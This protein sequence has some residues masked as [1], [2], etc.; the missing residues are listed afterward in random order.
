MS[1]R[2]P[3]YLGHRFRTRSSALKRPASALLLCV[4]LMLSAVAQDMEPR[5][6]TPLP[7][8]MNVIGAGY[9]K[10]SGDIL[11]D[12]VLKLENVEVD[13]NTLGISYVRSFPLAGKSARF[14]LLIPWQNIRW[15]GLL[16]GE[17]AS[18]TRVGLA[19][20]RLR[21]SVLLA[22]A[23]AMD[24]AEYRRHA[25]A[26]RTNTILGASVAV[27]VPAGEYFEDK[28][29]NLGQNRYII[30]PQLG[31]VHTRG[32]WA[33]ELTGSTL[34]FTDNDDFFGS[35]KRE[36]EP[37]YSVQGHV[38]RV[39]RP[40]VWASVG[41]LYAK[42]GK[43]R[44]NGVRKDDQRGDFVAGAAFGVPITPSQGVKIAY[45][46]GRTRRDTGADTQSLII[47]WSRR[48]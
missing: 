36:Q 6:W 40:G 14:D 5:R 4:G 29:L 8:G 47:A 31:V 21:V 45:V 20:P 1:T 48:F 23:P 10:T 13:A 33:Y 22:G 38:T 25:V 2:N 3:R 34:F 44:V 18:A 46:L 32:P 9:A 39:F 28:L 35:N 7:V 15:D 24:S 11:F 42:G 43:S 19:D 12:P 26:N 17:F 27:H 30:V 37:L 41:A 16:D